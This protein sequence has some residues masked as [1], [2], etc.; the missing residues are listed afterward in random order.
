MRAG[1]LSHMVIIQYPST[2]KAQGVATTT[3]INFATV[4]ASI[5]QL[6]GYDKA[7]AQASWPGADYIIGIRYIPGVT[8]KMRCV[9]ENGVIYSIVG[10]PND[11]GNSHVN[12]ELTCQSGVKG[13]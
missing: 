9:D 6:K 12:I 7:N 13:S 8:S 1:M 2:V 4:A 5:Y 11:K 3:W 10:S